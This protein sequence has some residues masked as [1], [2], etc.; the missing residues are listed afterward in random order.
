MI[1]NYNPDSK[2]INASSVH[3]IQSLDAG[4]V[5]IEREIMKNRAIIYSVVLISVLQVNLIVRSVAIDTMHG[6]LA[7]RDDLLIGNFTI[8]SSAG[9]L[10]KF[11]LDYIDKMAEAGVKVAHGTNWWCDNITNPLD[12]IYNDTIR[13]WA[14]EMID[15][16]LNIAGVPSFQDPDAPP[17]ERLV[18]RSSIWAIGLGDEEPAWV[19]YADIWS[20]LSD[21]IAKYDSLYFAETGFHLRPLY[22]ANLTEYWTEVEWLNNKTVWV[23]NYF[24]D[25]VKS[26]FP[27]SKVGQGT[28]MS[29]TWGI[30]V[31][32]CAPYE[33]KADQTYMDC[34]YAKDDPW[35]LYETI[36][37]YKTSIPDNPLF[38]T[39]WGTIWDF[40]NEAGDG[41]YYH[42][43]SYEQIRRETWVSYVSGVD[44][45]G[46]FD[47]APENNNSFTWYWG[48]FRKDLAGR[49]LFR[50]VDN[51]AGQLVRLPTLNS[52]PKVLVV[53]DG[54]NTGEPMPHVSH[55]RLFTEYDLVN[56]R[57]FATTDI[58]LS[59]YS[60]ILMTDHW[61]YN[62][63]VAKINDFVANGGSVVFLGG[64]GNEPR[65]YDKRIGYSIEKRT[66]EYDVSGHILLNITEPNILGL[67][68][69]HDALYHSTYVLNSENF[70]E[71]YHPIGTEY[72]VY[73][74]GTRTKIN[75]PAIVLYHDSSNPQSG[76]V[77]YFGAM[78]STTDP[79]DA[80]NY[81]FEHEPDLWNLYKTV[82]RG[83]AGFLNITNSIS[84]A[85]TENMLVT[86]G[87][88]DEDTMLAAICN[89]NNESR[90]FTYRV[91]LQEFGLP[92]GTYWI[93]SL[94]E[95]RSL[96]TADSIKGTLS[97]NISV[98]TNGTRLL[99][100]SQERPTPDFEINIF[101]AIPDLTDTI[102][103]TGTSPLPQDIVIIIV[104]TSTGVGLLIMAIV[105]YHRRRPE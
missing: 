28:F 34:Y 82:V 41:L 44:A 98:V 74:N 91:D 58:D 65:P 30:P 36:R 20:E 104:V 17:P 85:E 63:T 35:L 42:E 37:R 54:Y 76:W 75:D 32:L 89:F 69:E 8:W 94:D 101:P 53:G 1:Y 27:D 62:S 66:S 96:G 100:I 14:L 38:M 99:L 103:S 7:G 26:Q 21:D 83:F 25:Y 105:V 57:C 51:L 78:D 60:M 22:E 6:G 68:L 2:A 79:A 47:W 86:Q 72:F 97:F 10:E 90:E 15:F 33:L 11:D 43:G 9:Q 73:D 45:L 19:R 77:L 88:V 93:H 29:P 52:T 95:N 24:Y 61:H 49:R 18:N 81:D 92:D 48:H 55:L 87:M 84:T 40:L 50:Y 31:D 13:Q 39:I 70:T 71:D 46:F 56:Q 64:I 80:E 16:G 5:D 4:L 12:I 67:N 102:T 59:K 3:T 23:Y